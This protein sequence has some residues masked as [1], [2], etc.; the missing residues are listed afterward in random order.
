MGEDELKNEFSKNEKNLPK[1]PLVY[2]LKT[3]NISYITPWRRR[4]TSKNTELAY[5][6]NLL[7]AWHR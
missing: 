4:K 5:F 6:T 2:H 7:E 1:N 3:T